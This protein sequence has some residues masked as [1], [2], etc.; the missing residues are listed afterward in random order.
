[1]VQFNKTDTIT[2]GIHV[3]HKTDAEV[4]DAIANAEANG[5]TMTVQWNGTPTAQASVTYGLRKPPIYAKVSE[6]ERPDGT[7]ERVM[8]WGHYVTNPED[9]Q[10]F[11]S[12]EEAREYF[13]L[14]V[15]NEELNNSE[16]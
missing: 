4:L 11:L 13:G 7:T 5:W 15:E 16:Q 9:Y 2:L 1:M 8:D 3:D 6:M 14:P 12:L 10:E